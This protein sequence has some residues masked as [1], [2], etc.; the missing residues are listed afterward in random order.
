M[1]AVEGVP[2]IHLSLESRQAPNRV[3]CSKS[4]G[5]HLGDLGRSHTE[6]ERF[7]HRPDGTGMEGLRA[8]TPFRLPCLARSPQPSPHSHRDGSGVAVRKWTQGCVGSWG[9]TDTMLAVVRKPPESIQMPLSLLLRMPII[10]SAVMP[11]ARAEGG[12]PASD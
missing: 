7:E 10:A 11:P 2:A 8:I 5:Q 9:S 3:L 1:S 6:D 12:P 4:G